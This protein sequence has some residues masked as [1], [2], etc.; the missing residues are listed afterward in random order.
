[1]K[2]EY[3]TAGQKLGVHFKK[4]YDSDGKEVSYNNLIDFGIPMGSQVKS[5]HVASYWFPLQS[6]CS[7]N[8]IRAQLKVQ[9]TYIRAN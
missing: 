9:S 8:F 3:N 6:S 7:F 2:Y 5:N 4:S 1:M